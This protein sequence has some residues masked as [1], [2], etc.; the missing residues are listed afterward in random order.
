M[1]NTA[2]TAPSPPVIFVL[3][4]RIGITAKQIEL[5]PQADASHIGISSTNSQYSAYQ[6]HLND[7]RFIGR[8]IWYGRSLAH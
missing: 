5:I 7:I 4:D 3:F 1:V 8:V 6:R 2:D